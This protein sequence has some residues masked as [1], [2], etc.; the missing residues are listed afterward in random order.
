M[1]TLERRMAVTSLEIREDADDLTLTGYAST[2]GQP[3]SMGWYTE[4]VDRDAFK[5]TLGQKPDVRLLINHDGLPLAR[6]TSGTLTLSSD[7]K[8]LLASAQLDR[9]DPDVQSILPKMQR[10][11]LN[12]MSFGF[13]VVEDVWENDMTKRTLRQLD[14]NGGDV[15]VVTYPAN[16]NT[17][18]SLRAGGNALE[19]IASAMREMETRKA[20]DD[21]VRALLLRMLGAYGDPAPVEE[22]SVA[23]IVAA[24]DAAVTQTSDDEEAARHALDLLNHRKRRALAL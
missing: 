9:S 18:V 6:T 24:V 14:L 7:S 1:K 2:Y 23:E 19:A 3:Y 10:G 5:R 20:D 13:R 21:D 4:S 17:S 8:G 22:A 12:E 15:S 16:P 11:D